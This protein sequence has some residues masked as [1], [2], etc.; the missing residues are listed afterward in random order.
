M[1]RVV[2]DSNLLQ[3]DGLR[4]YL[5]ASPANKAVIIDYAEVE[6]LKGGSRHTAEIDGA[7]AP[8]HGFVFRYA[9][10]ATM[11]ALRWIAAGGAKGGGD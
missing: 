5:L 10:C 3:G 2:V 6:A 9:L 7:S 8:L 11:H 1:K 4:E